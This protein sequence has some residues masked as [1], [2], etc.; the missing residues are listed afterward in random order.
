MRQAGRYRRWTVRDRLG[1]PAGP[2]RQARQAARASLLVIL[3]V[4]ALTMLALQAGQATASVRADGGDI[5]R[6]LLDAG[7]S[8][9]SP[10][11]ISGSAVQGQTLSADPGSW[12][13]SPT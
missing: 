2:T 4:L 6:Q 1:Q 12:T 11:T 3:G 13:N 10:P 8:N 9:T 5:R 7:P